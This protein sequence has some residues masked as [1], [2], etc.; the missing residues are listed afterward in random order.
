MT[1]PAECYKNLPYDCCKCEYRFYPV[2]SIPC[3]C[4]TRNPFGYCMLMEKKAENNKIFGQY[5]NDWFSPTAEKSKGG[6]SNV[7]ESNNM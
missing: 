4:C 6:H 1:D 5:A 3:N 2:R 7:L